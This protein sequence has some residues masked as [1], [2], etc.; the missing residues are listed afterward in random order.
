M[1][2][3]KVTEVIPKKSPPHVIYGK[4]KVRTD[5][6]VG[7]PYHSNEEQNELKGEKG[8]RVEEDWEKKI[9]KEERMV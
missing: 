3:P 8:E 5:E 7:C 2:T 1:V 4:P 9:K 6:A